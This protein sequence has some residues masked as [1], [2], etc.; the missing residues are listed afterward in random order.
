MHR[1]R[2][3]RPGTRLV[4]RRWPHATKL[5]RV[6]EISSTD[7][8][9]LR[10]RHC[11]VTRVLVVGGSP[12]QDVSGLNVQGVGADGPRSGLFRHVPRV[13]ELCA[14]AMKGVGVDWMIENVASMTP[15]S[16]EVYSKL[17]AVGDKDEET[18]HEAHDAR[19][20]A[21]VRAKHGS[22]REN[23]DFRGHFVN[24]RMLWAPI[25][26]SNSF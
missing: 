17:L 4:A 5:S 11:N 25:C 2:P 19:A 21:E 8:R 14:S 26:Q 7:I 13:A 22:E 20:E 23:G 15:E 12:C 18:G 3:G 9:Q 24:F 10:R 1:R 16:R 6:E